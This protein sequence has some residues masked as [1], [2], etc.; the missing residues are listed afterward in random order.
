M[1]I[2]LDLISLLITVFTIGVGVG[3]YFREKK[4]EKTFNPLLGKFTKQ[5][6]QM[7]DEIKKR[8]LRDTP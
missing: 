1:E 6:G 7:W 8:G 4:D 2:T 3:A 5:K